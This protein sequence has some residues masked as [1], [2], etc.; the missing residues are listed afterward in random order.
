MNWFKYLCSIN[1][2][3]FF[4]MDILALLSRVIFGYWQ[5]C[6]A[7]W[8]FMFVIGAIIIMCLTPKMYRTAKRDSQLRELEEMERNQPKWT[9]TETYK[10]K[11]RRRTRL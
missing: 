9:V 7:F 10:G 2:F 8:I 3:Y 11:T 4:K 1:I 6:S 5:L